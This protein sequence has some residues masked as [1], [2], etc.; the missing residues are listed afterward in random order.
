MYRWNVDKHEISGSCSVEHLV[1]FIEVLHVTCV[2]TIVII[3]FGTPSDVV[4]SSVEAR[5]KMDATLAQRH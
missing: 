3:L 4:E 2:R 1:A 5:L